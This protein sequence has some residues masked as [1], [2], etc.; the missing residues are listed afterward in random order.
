MNDK[1]L[2]NTRALNDLSDLVKKEEERVLTIPDNNNQEEDLSSEELFNDLITKEEPKKEEPDIPTK[3]TL[4]EKWH[5]LSKKNK[6]I[7]IGMAIA[8]VLISLIT[9]LFLLNY[10]K[11][12]D[13][14][15]TPDT[16]LAKDNYIYQNGTLTILDDNN[17]PIGSYECNN[18]DEN[19]CYVAFLNNDEDLFEAPQNEYQDGTIIRTRSKVYFNKYVFITDQSADTKDIVYLYNL[20]TNEKVGEYLGVKA[21]SNHDN[22][23]VL[24]NKANQY[25]LFELTNDNLKTIIDYSYTY[26]GIVNKENDNKLVVKNNKST[27]LVD[28][29]NKVKTKT[30]TGDIIDYND[31]YIVIKN[32]NNTYSVVDYDNQEYNSQYQYIRLID[33]NHV[34]IVIDNNL[35]IRNVNNSKYN[36]DGIAL[37]NNV[38]V[39]VNIYDENNKKTST[40]YSFTTEINNNVLDV[41]VHSDTG[42]TETNINLREGDASIKY[43]YINYF[44]GKLYFYS[45]EAKEKLISTYTCNNQNDIGDD[46]TLNN[47]NIATDTVYNDN[48]LNP[49]NSR[50]SVIP[51]YNYKYAFIYD[52]PANATDTNKEIKFYDLKNSKTL[53]TYASIDSSTPD[54][55]GTINQVTTNATTIIAKLK[56][57]KYGTINITSNDAN[58]GYKFE[59]SYLENF[60]KYYLAQ[61]ENNK[62]QVLYS[63]DTKS[64]EFPYK[65]MNINSSYAV[66]RV[67]DGVR[68]YK[69]DATQVIDKSYKFI[70]L[71]DKLAFGAVDSSNNKLYVIKYDGTILNPD[72]I[73]LPTDNYYNT[74]T[75]AFKMEIVGDVVNVSVFDGKSYS[76]TIK[77]STTT[78]TT[79]SEVNTNATQE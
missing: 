20:E 36:E 12:K 66:L 13:T 19:L 47:C 28:F 46:L 48:Y 45:D 8:I 5:N 21:Y 23:V 50:N 54:N 34:A 11:K 57:G 78:S 7:I 62:W 3:L 52:S 24:K 53:G 14:P 77:I 4:K 79:N 42:N 26:I 58:V 56:S 40:N 27:Y 2:E 9:T 22:N 1:N 32:S 37:N 25:G 74:S 39:P 17:N 6:I 72:G 76:N 75:P 15:V 51:I 70:Y 49:A 69:A 73:V 18:K 38:Y 65:I 30:I 33:S 60:G 68:L 67:N 64:Y 55:K 44:D 71:T 10:N 59:Y 35:Y 16:V 41:S 31:S 61:N 63:S 29:D 43:N